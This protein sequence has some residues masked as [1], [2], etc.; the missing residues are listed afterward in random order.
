M[1][2]SQNELSGENSD[3]TCPWNPRK[4]TIRENIKHLESHGLENQSVLASCIKWISFD[5]KHLQIGGI[6]NLF[7]I[8]YWA[9]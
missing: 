5:R 4:V 1:Q 7:W 6:N 8:T 2:L 3:T 9:R